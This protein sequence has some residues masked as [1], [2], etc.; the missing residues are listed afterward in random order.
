MI[1]L[2]EVSETNEM[3]SK[4]NLD[5]R[6]IT[7][8]ISLLDCIDSDLNKLKKNIHDKIYESAK[9]L[10]A[11]GDKIS[12][13]YGIPIVNK[14]ISVTPIG[15]IGGSAC[16]S[17]DDFASIAVTLDEVAKEVGVNFACTGKCS[18]GDG[19]QFHRRILSSCGK[20]YD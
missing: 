12:R 17:E 8:G 16:R 19:S 18:Q 3:I 10:V 6:T 20:G 14:R 5:V 7:L 13:Y 15:L 11:T 9:D 2:R 4:E 1:N